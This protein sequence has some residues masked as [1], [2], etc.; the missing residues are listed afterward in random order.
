MK[1]ILGLIIVASVLATG[2]G[3]SETEIALPAD[4]ATPQAAVTTFLEAIRQGIDKDANRMLTPMARQK[5]QER[6]VIATPPGSATAKFTVGD[7][8]YVTN[9]KDGAHVAASWTDIDIQGKPSTENFIWVLRKESEGWRIAGMAVKVFDDE[10]PLILNFEDPDDVIR[11][12]Q[13]LAEEMARRENAKATAEAKRPGFT[14]P[15]LK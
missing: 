9:E 6:G 15:P 12:Q 11:K 7:A 13:L 1:R 4:S 3:K 14:E 5:N 10:L 2:C 8:E